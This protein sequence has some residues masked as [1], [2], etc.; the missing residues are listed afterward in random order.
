MSS[1]PCQIGKIIPVSANVPCCTEDGD[2]LLWLGASSS[3]H[4][5]P[6]MFHPSPISFPINLL[7]THTPH[8]PAEKRPILPLN[9]GQDG[10]WDSPTDNIF[11][12]RHPSSCSSSMVHD[13]GVVDESLCESMRSYPTNAV[14][15]LA[16]KQQQGRLQKP[17]LL[18][19]DVGAE[20]KGDQEGKVE[21]L[22]FT[23]ITPENLKRLL[24]RS[25]GVLC[26]TQQTPQT[27]QTSRP[28]IINCR[29]SFA[30][31]PMTTQEPLHPYIDQEATKLTDVNEIEADFVQEGHSS[32]R[33]FEEMEVDKGTFGQ[34]DSQQE[35]VERTG[36]VAKRARLGSP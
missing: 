3:L 6:P 20:T 19:I 30:N 2:D 28:K 14:V 35:L 16:N 13:S 25:P 11:H 23:P 8:S 17:K 1:Y 9:I 24:Q 26:Q 31:T 10:W 18:E 22:P 29:A 5:A 12:H 4:A 33:R 27:P 36:W 7:S 32:R 34:M 15:Q 21:L